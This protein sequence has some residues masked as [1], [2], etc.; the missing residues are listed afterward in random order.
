MNKKCLIAVFEVIS[1][2]AGLV[3]KFHN[4]TAK[5]HCTATYQSISIQEDALGILRQAP[6]VQLCERYAEL[7]STQQR[8][9][10]SVLTVQDINDCDEVEH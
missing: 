8:Q 1:G 4:I 6:A 9:V 5:G 10:C 7:G 3:L 2:L